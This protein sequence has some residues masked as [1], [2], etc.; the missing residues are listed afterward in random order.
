MTAEDKLR[1]TTI[2]RLMCDLELNY[3]Q[4]SNLLG[5]DFYEHFETDINSLDDMEA[6]GLVERSETGL[7]VTDLGRLLIRNIAMRFDAYAT[8]RKEARFSKTI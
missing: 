8:E 2:M 1:R 3:A 4:M 6:D 5:T 7:K